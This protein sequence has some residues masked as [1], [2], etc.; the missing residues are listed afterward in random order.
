M[1]WGMVADAYNPST[2]E[3][4]AGGLWVR[5][6]PGLRSETLLKNNNNNKTKNIN[7]RKM[8]WRHFQLQPIYILDNYKQ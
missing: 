7:K 6:W 5:D 3:A 4:K 8:N 2:G 1:K